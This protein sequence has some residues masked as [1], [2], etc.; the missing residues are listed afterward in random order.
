MRK[1]HDHSVCPSFNTELFNKN[2]FYSTLREQR[3]ID[4][5]HQ[6]D[7]GGDLVDVYAEVALNVWLTER[8][9]EFNS[10][11]ITLVMFLELLHK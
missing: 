8:V 1:A 10:L 2:S 9:F 4:F 5:A 7:S 11:T 3:E 6:T